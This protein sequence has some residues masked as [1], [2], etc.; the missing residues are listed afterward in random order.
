MKSFQIKF[1]LKKNTTSIMNICESTKI[2]TKIYVMC[3]INMMINDMTTNKKQI[4]H[5]EK[6]NEN[7]H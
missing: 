5:I 6:K 1:F 4:H 3:V 2:K 7:V